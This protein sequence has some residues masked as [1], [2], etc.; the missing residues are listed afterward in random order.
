VLPRPIA[1]LAVLTL[2]LLSSVTVFGANDRFPSSD[3]NPRVGTPNDPKFDCA[4]ADDEDTDVPPCSSVWEEQWQ[5]FGFAPDYT[6]RTATYHDAARLGQGQISGVSADVAWKTTLGRPDVAIAILDTG[7]EWYDNSLRTKIWLNQNELPLPQLASD[8]TA[9]NHDANG[10]GA[11]N[12]SDYDNDARVNK[13]AG[14]N[15]VANSIDAQDLIRTFSDNTDADNNGYID[16]IA[17]WDF[18]DDDNDPYDASSYSSADGHGTG[19]AKEAAET[20]NDGSGDAGLCPNCQVMPLRVFDV[21]VA[22]GDSYAMATIYAADNGADVQE[23]SLGVLQNSKFA[24]FATQYAFD[25]GLALMQVSSDLNTSS[26]NYPTNYNNTIFV[27]GSVADAHGLGQNEE[28]FAEYFRQFGIGTNVPVSTW[29]RNANTTQFGGHAAIVMMGDTGSQATGQSS[30]AAGLLVSRG[31]EL[32]DDI[33]GRLTSNE[34]KQILTMTAEDVL[35]ENT[36]GLGIPDPAQVGWDQHFGYGRVNLGAAVQSVAPGNIPPEAGIESPAWFAPLDP[37]ATPMIPISGFVS[38]KRADNYY[39]MLQYAPGL[40]PVDSAYQTFAVASGSGSFKGNIGTLN[41]AAVANKLPGAA[42]GIPPLDPYQYAFTVRLRVIDNLGNAAEDRKTLFA[43]HDPTLKQGWPKNIDS[44]GE[45]SMRF[46]DLNGDGVQEIITANSSGE[47]DVWTGSGTRAPYFNNGQTW[48]APVPSLISNHLPDNGTIPLGRTG[49]TTPAIDDVNGDGRLDIVVANGEK[50][51][52]LRYNGTV[53]P[54]FPVSINTAFSAPALRTKTNHI[55]PG[56][57]SSPVLADLNEDGKLDIVVAALDQRAYAWSG[58]GALLP[59]WPVFM[60]DPNA[61]IPAG[62]ESINTPA[63]ADVDGDGHLDVIVP[64]NEIYAGSVPAASPGDLSDALA[65]GLLDTVLSSAGLVSSRVYAIRHNGTLADGNT[66]DNNGFVVDAD[67]FLSGWPVKLGGVA[68][69]LPLVGPGLDPVIADVDADGAPEIVLGSTLGSMI[70]FGGDGHAKFS[71]SPGPAGANAGPGANFNLF[72][73][74]AVGDTTGLGA[75]SIYKGGL[76]AAGLVNLVAA[77]QNLPFTHVVQGWDA[78]TGA[79]L[80][81]WPRATDD[82]QLLSSPSIANVGGGP[83]REVIVG[84]GL[85]LLHAYGPTGLEPAGFPKFTGGW[86]SGTTPIGDVD[87][88]GLLEIAN[89][90]REGNVFVWDTTVSVCDGDHEWPGFR[91]DNRNTGAYETDAEAPGTIHDLTATSVPITN[92]VTMRWTAPGGDGKCGQADHYEIRTSRDPITD[93]NWSAAQ[94]VATKAALPAGT[95]ELHIIPQAPP[96]NRYFA[97]RAFDAAGNA[98][99]MTMVV[100][101]G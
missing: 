63:I 9:A 37:V 6:E 65:K 86:L 24:K 89:W 42:Q 67:A 91:H 10:D 2:I 25:K 96:N 7:I 76:P 38:A 54:G 49:F 39:Y 28:Q 21:F 94:L 50:V 58:T 16:D 46:A 33:G 66:T 71:L 41:L 27:A 23:V 1:V 32:A 95:P 69:I 99:R 26:H 70:V 72:E 18:F 75:L 100:R 45:S 12:V 84:T 81:G 98:G 8:A 79:S 77:G 60:Q 19:R 11:F 56:I 93:S 82:W 85:Y 43:F 61:A 73:Y 92:T 47:L 48:L 20:T 80:P 22:P 31:L 53:L 55:K 17:A 52:A 87:G 101:P 3:P 97:I 14:P 74:P 88:D 4:E 29:F 59:G 57:F 83:E 30:G 35:P 5:A 15:G 78:A 13:N 62:A 34:I 44:G 36:V 64:T 51:F 40:E 68:D 90:T